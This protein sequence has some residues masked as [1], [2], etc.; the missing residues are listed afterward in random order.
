MKFCTQ[1]GNP[2][3]E[4]TKFC[5]QCGNPIPQPAPVPEQAAPVSE[6]IPVTE[7]PVSTPEIVIPDVTVPEIPETT[8]GKT[9]VTETSKKPEKPVKKS[10]GKKIALVAVCAV[11]ALAIVA[12]VLL[13]FLGN[14]KDQEEILGMYEGISYRYEDVDISAEDDWIELKPFGIAKLML[15]GDEYFAFWTLDGRDFTLK[16]G[17]STYEGTLKN[18][19]L[20]LDLDGLI[21]TY[22][23]DDVVDPDDD[24]GKGKDDKPEEDE[25]AEEPAADAPAADAPAVDAP[26]VEVSSPVGYWTLK[27]TTGE[28]D[29]TKSEEE[30]AAMAEEGINFFIDLYDDGTGYISWAEL[31]A[32]TWDDSTLIGPDGTRAPYTMENGELVLDIE[33]TLFH[34]V[35]GEGSAPTTEVT[36]ADPNSLAYYAGD[37]YGW[38]LY[39]D[40]VVGDQELQGYWWDCCMTLEFTG[41]DTFYL[42]IW[43]EDLDKTDPLAEVEGYV[44]IN[45]GVA[46]FTSESGYFFDTTVGYG[47]WTFTSNDTIYENT[48]GFNAYY[49]GSDLEIDCYFL[50]RPW[51]IIWDDVEEADL[52][53]YYEDWYLPLIEEGVT[54]APSTIG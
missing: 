46:E 3:S 20:T 47:D 30:I 43:D 38:W 22:F 50:L 23:N 17:G 8:P 42:V 18:G 25:P 24:E 27:Y 54:E 41:E 14:I 4:G 28:D 21:Y 49:A 39:E 44:T 45:D 40:V 34:F 11:L 9:S 2:L 26:A 52:P 48:I 12:G 33:G 53:Y 32:I 36:V 10:N 37:Y 35:P 19:N 16:Q 29:M 15:A 1:C 7:Q 31:S 5:T 6:Q 13:L 51:G